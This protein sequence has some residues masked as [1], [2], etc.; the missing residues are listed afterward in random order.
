MTTPRPEDY[1]DEAMRRFRVT[2]AILMIPALGG[3]LAAPPAPPDELPMP[4]RLRAEMTIVHATVDPRTE[5]ARKAVGGLL[6]DLPD[7]AKPMVQFPETSAMVTMT[8]ERW[9]SPFERETLQAAIASTGVDGVIKAMKGLP[10]LGDLHIDA[11][12]V[13]IRIAATWMTEH[14]QHVRLVFNSRLV[15]NQD[16]LS[17][18]GR[19]LD[20]L[21]LTLPFGEPFGT[22]SLVTATKV[23]FVESG[24]VSPV[25][26]A[27]DSVT[28]PLTKVEKQSADRH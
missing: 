12:R 28:Q 5:E 21:D 13:P 8:I 17:Q 27:L 24:L 19:A 6:G 1:H 25:T 15:P 20:I 14:T 18:S 11:Q 16:S 9:T 10:S 4:A 2:A 23:E 26:F 22:G 3:L 7:R